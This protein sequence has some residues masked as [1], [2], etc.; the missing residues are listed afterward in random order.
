MSTPA[1]PIRVR[2]AIAGDIPA[3]ANL[4][5]V[6]FA[7]ETEFT[8]DAT[9]Q[10][11]GLQLILADANAGFILVAEQQGTL[12]GTVNV[13]FSVSTALGQRVGTVED[14]I[15]LPA[16]RGSGVGSQLLEAAIAEAQRQGCGRLTL[17]TDGDNEAAHRF[18]LK[19]GFSRSSMVPFRQRL[20]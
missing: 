10:Q 3:L 5:G 20:C 19:H 7:Q 2:P 13:L 12:V 17:L 9:A 15:V 18:Y 8:P 4:L 16:V 6:L 11:R 1:K 14:M